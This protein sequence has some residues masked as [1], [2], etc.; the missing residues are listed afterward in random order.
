MA[1]RRYPTQ[2]LKLCVRGCKG[3]SVLFLPSFDF[4]QQGQSFVCIS[5]PAPLAHIGLTSLTW[6]LDAAARVWATPFSR[7]STACRSSFWSVTSK[8]LA[9]SGRRSW[10]TELI[11][12]VIWVGHTIIYGNYESVHLSRLKCQTDRTKALRLLLTWAP[13]TKV[14]LTKQIVPVGEIQISFTH[15]SRVTSGIYKKE[16]ASITLS[17]YLT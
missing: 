2:A 15:V 16:G 12:W 11:S 6:G 5:S 14:N 10:R 13:A 9:V 4:M 17:L 3:Y 1:Q 7:C 8:L